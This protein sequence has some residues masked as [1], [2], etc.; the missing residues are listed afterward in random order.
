MTSRSFK[1]DFF[2]IGVAKAGT[3]TLHDLLDL[4]DRIRLPKRKE[5]NY[6]SFGIAGK[7]DFAGPLDNAS[8]NIPTIT[9]LEDY[10]ADFDN[11]DGQEC[12][13]GEVCP[14]YALEGTAEN[15]YQHNPRAK[16]VIL[17]REPVARAF[18][19]YQHLVRDGR[20]YESFEAALE[21][22]EER[23][24]NNWEWFWGLKRNSYYFDTVKTYINIFGEE[25][26]KVIFFEDF[27]RDQEESLRSVL[28]FVGHET[29]TVR[30]QIFESNKS[31]VVSGKWL[32]LHKVLLSEGYLNSALRKILPTGFRK[33]MGQLFKRAS[34][35]RAEVSPETQRFLRNEFKSDL[36]NLASLTGGRVKDWLEAGHVS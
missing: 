11:C 25:N 15:L 33:Q 31:G 6:F 10:I 34:T 26:V 13:Y 8:V 1:V 21:A 9:S 30:Y 18:S 12:L 5:T 14:S 7:P 2:C 4:Q 17:L 23:L 22:E 19:N 24:G 16:I 29:D 3:T 27:V 28:A 36:E 32:F 20:E 35:V